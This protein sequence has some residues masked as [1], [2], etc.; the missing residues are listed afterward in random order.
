[1]ISLS[2]SPTGKISPGFPDEA[3]LAKSASPG[4][5]YG[6]VFKRC[7]DLLL[8]LSVLPVLAILLGAVSILIAREGGP[9]FYRQQR[10]GRGGVVFTILK[11]RTMVVNAEDEL[12]EYLAR[13]P[14]ARA[15]WNKHQ[16]L[17]DDP[18]VTRVGRF[19]RR[20]SMDEL[21]QLFNVLK[22]DMSL[23]G[24]R[25]MMVEQAPL[26]PGQAYYQLRP[27]ITGPWQVSDRHESS[28][29]DRARFDAD[30]ARSLSFGLDL[31]LLVR[32]VGVV[33]K[34]GGA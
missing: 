18:R 8:V 19:L 12:E 9:V 28:F 31:R 29:A 21:P 24:P 4:R 27:G 30:Y 3:D 34:C 25:P 33:L 1:M 23:V 32:T 26:Y 22:G 10:I 17:K 20:S 5:L 6:G 7:F 2:H 16:K 13:N 11:F 15:E 14:L